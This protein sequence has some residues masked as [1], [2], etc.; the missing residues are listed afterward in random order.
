MRVGLITWVMARYL[1][2]S[3]LCACVRVGTHLCVYVCL[4]QPNHNLDMW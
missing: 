3:S 2:S 1:L 4:C